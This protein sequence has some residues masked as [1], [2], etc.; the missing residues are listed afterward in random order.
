MSRYT[1]QTG[2]HI[3]PALRRVI[4]ARDA[5]TCQ[6]CERQLRPVA[7]VVEHIIPAALGGPAQPYNLVTACYGCNSR[8]G[9]RVWIP[10]N[11]DTITADHLEWRAKVQQA[12]IPPT[13][14]RRRSVLVLLTSDERAP[15]EA[16]AQA[17]NLS[18]SDTIRRILA[19][20]VA[21]QEAAHAPRR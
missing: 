12:A 5:E 9:R 20:W 14:E 2:Q 8:K 19:A 4:L 6:Y 10:C 21:Q 3:L 16:Y 17:H 7:L 13:R 18:T 15:I 11:L 1:P